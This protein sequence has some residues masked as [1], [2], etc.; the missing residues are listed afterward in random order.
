MVHDFDIA[1]RVG[2]TSRVDDALSRCRKEDLE[3]SAIFRLLWLIILPSRMRFKLMLSWAILS[4]IRKR[5]QLPVALHLGVELVA[6]QRRLV[7]AQTS[8]WFPKLLQEFHTIVTDG[9]SE[10]YR[11]YR[12]LGPSLKWKDMKGDITKFVVKCHTCPHSKFQKKILGEK[13]LFFFFVKQ[14]RKY[15]K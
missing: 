5:T 9:H 14:K 15:I 4:N 12:S 13:A 3:L 10:I 1:Y 11:T 6:F 2:T 8:I 7:L